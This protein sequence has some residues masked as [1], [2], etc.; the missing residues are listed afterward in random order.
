MSDIVSDSHGREAK[1]HR[2]QLE[3]STP[4]AEKLDFTDRRS[5][6]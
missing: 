1:D 4:L 3:L 6:K 2:H 5:V